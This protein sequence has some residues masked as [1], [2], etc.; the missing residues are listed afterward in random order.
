MIVKVK[1]V[2]A[3]P[4]GSNRGR[5]RLLSD[6]GFQH[7]IS[8]NFF[9]RSRICCVTA[10]DSTQYDPEHGLFSHTG[11]QTGGRGLGGCSP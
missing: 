10:N 11:V 6:V 7:R 8:S 5:W 4:D 9:R 3:Y 2:E 1:L